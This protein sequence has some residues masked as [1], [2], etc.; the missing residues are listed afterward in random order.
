VE[1]PITIVFEP[2]SQKELRAI[3]RMR[4]IWV[5]GLIVALAIGTLLVVS[6]V[7]RADAVASISPAPL[8]LT[9]RPT[10]AQVW[11]DGRESGRTP[12]SLLV[13]PGVHSV[14][15]KASDAVD[16]QYTLQVG[17][18]GAAF[19]IGLLRRRPSLMRLRPTL[20]GATLVDVRLLSDGQLALAMSVPPGKQIQAWRLDPAS[21]ALEALL[22]EASGTRVAF[23]PDGERVAYT[24]YEVGPTPS[25]TESSMLWLVDRGRAVPTAGWRAPL[26]N[27]ERLLDASWSPRDDQLLVVSSRPQP[28]GTVR[29]RAWFVDADGQRAREA[30]S[31]PS[32]VVPGS[33]VWSPDGAHVVFLAHAGAVNALCLLD[34]Q[35]DF[36]YVADLDASALPPLAYPPAS[37]STDSQRVVFVAPH[38]RP[39]GVSVGWLQQPEAP[40][41]LYIANVS[42]TAAVSS[43]DTPLDFATWRED[44]QLFGL[45]RLGNGGALDLRLVNAAG[46]GQHLLELPFKPGP[47]YGAVWDTA[48]TRL[49]VA[50]PNQSGGVDYWLAMLGVESAS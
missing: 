4:G 23:A 26:T 12:L 38:Q 33:A 2:P 13:E 48:H 24:G 5:A 47:S 45:G 11:L 10:G 8:E 3:L 15:L 17:A 28:G 49:L 35:G 50:N 19:D 21:G 36:R 6:G 31:L 41:S 14:L 37:W 22:A 1:L 40:H 7:G 34:L 16:G 20:P 42:E 46:S 25:P 30:L 18:D 43:G 9:S 39:A 27:G 29:S 32:E 44:G